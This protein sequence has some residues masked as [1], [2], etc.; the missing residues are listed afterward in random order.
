MIPSDLIKMKK[1][2]LLNLDPLLTSARLPGLNI[3]LAAESP[4]PSE[5]WPEGAEQISQL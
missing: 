5:A 3:L 2:N 4:F 1:Q